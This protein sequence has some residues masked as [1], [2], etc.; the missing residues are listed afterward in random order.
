MNVCKSKN[1]EFAHVAFV[2]NL[3]IFFSLIDDSSIFLRFSR[4]NIV[5]IEIKSLIWKCLTISQ[6]CRHYQNVFKKIFI[7]TK[8]SIFVSRFRIFKFS[9]FKRSRLSLFIWFFILIFIYLSK[10][11]SKYNNIFFIIKTLCRRILCINNYFS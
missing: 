11:I 8:R 9:K 6:I 10:L 2:S 4:T 7:L 1:N 5:K 3:F